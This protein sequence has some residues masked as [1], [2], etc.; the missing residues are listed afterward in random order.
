MTIKDISKKLVVKNIKHYYMLGFSVIMSITMITSLGLIIFSDSIQANITKGGS[1]YDQAVSAL[2]LALVC[3]IFFVLYSNQLFIKYKS[4]EI[5]IFA[6]LGMK[7]KNIRSILLKEL[8]MILPICIILGLILSIPVSFLF[9]RVVA[10]LLRL[11]IGFKLGYIGLLLGSSVGLVI[12][13]AQRTAVTI[14]I[15]RTQ[16]IKLVSAENIPELK[17]KENRF[18]GLVY[19]FMTIIGT[20]AW[21]N[22]TVAIW[23][24]NV[25]IMA[26]L[27]AVSTIIFLYLTMKNM[28]TIGNLFKHYAPKYYYKN[29]V[30]F[31]FL[32]I[33]NKQYTNTFFSVILLV[34]I[35]IFMSISSF[36]PVVA[37]EEISDLL[38]PYSFSFRRTYDQNSTVEKEAVE[39]LAQENDITITSYSSIDYLVLARQEIDGY[40]WEM[41]VIDEAEYNNVFN[42]N[43]DVKKGQFAMVSSNKIDE[44]R[45]FYDLIE[46]YVIGSDYSQVL[47]R[48]LFIHEVLLVGGAAA[49]GDYYILDSKDFSRFKERSRKEAYESLD[50]FDVEDWRSSENFFNQL[51]TLLIKSNEK[52]LKIR[53]SLVGQ[54]YD[55]SKEVFVKID[56]IKESD[57]YNSNY[58]LSAR[59]KGSVYKTQRGIFSM[60]FVHIAIMSFIFASTILYVKVVN[61]TWRDQKVYANILLLGEK[62][63]KIKSIISKQLLLVYGTT[64]VLGIAFGVLVTLLTSYGNLFSDIYVKYSISIGSIYL[65]I[66]FIC[67]LCVRNTKLKQNLN[68]IS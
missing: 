30:F 25:S 55:N 38:N 43:I 61:T 3:S 20:V 7:R 66:Q 12:I 13:V 29:I 48:Q 28:F 16:I 22:C 65:L 40:Y 8:S 33:K 44:K 31:S 6:S 46:G 37:L 14:Y 4:K 23:F 56:E 32:K 39:A 64:T 11:D 41:V 19:L 5:G 57:I 51:N 35:T 10:S 15:K 60:L 50:F 67:F 36:I 45:K 49:R 34:A 59:I 1:V 62:R 21:Y 24:P 53:G 17:L 27:F 9:W 26:T 47:K 42:R 63:K 58:T 68:V 54:Y 52:G 18:N 2:F